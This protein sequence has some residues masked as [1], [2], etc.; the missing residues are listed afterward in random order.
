[1]LAVLVDE[2]RCIHYDRLTSGDASGSSWSRGS[3]F[4]ND[5][6][7]VRITSGS[8]ICGGGIPTQCSVADDF[9]TRNPPTGCLG[10]CGERCDAVQ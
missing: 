2:M 1:V 8:P 3:C 4:A 9:D 6:L 7:C 10:R 5:A